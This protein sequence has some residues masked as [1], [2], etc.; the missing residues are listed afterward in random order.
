MGH[1]AL[2]D[3]DAA[4]EGDD[5]ERPILLGRFASGARLVVFDLQGDGRSEILEPSAQGLV[6]HEAGPAPTPRPPSRR[7]AVQVSRKGLD[8]QFDLAHRML[9]FELYAKAEDAFRELAALSSVRGHAREEEAI[10]GLVTALASSERYDAAEGVI[11]KACKARRGVQRRL[12]LELTRIRIERAD[13]TGAAKEMDV[14]ATGEGLGLFERREAVATGRW[15]AAWRD[16]HVM[17]LPGPLTWATDDA[18][19][20]HV[21]E[22]GGIVIRDT[23]GR[24]VESRLQR[25]LPAGGFDLSFDVTFD[26]FASGQELRVGF[27]GPTPTDRRRRDHRGV[28]CHFGNT[29]GTGFVPTLMVVRKG[30]LDRVCSP[31]LEDGL[32]KGVVYHVRLVCVAGGRKVVLRI[33]HPDGSCFV[34]HVLTDVVLPRLGEAQDDAVREDGILLGV[35]QGMTAGRGAFQVRIGKME[36]GLPGGR[37]RGR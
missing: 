6:I 10:L 27:L 34:H 16:V 2:F 28:Y 30:T 18:T 20:F 25:A 9:D 29:T 19:R 26:G 22:D 35:S 21:E 5:G 11:E 31:S 8:L 32:Q 4:G 33:T 7:H 36:L 1:L 23:E 13:F 3:L 17:D 14:L 37:P 24:Q 12:D 15:L